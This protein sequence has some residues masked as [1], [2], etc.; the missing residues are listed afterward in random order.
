MKF[1]DLYIS[2]FDHVVASPET[3]REVLNMKDKNRIRF[4]ALV[5][6]VLLICALATTAFAYTGFV[7]YENPK[8]MIDAFFCGSGSDEG[9]IVVDENGQT[10]VYPSF[11]REGMN[12]SAAE[13]YVAPFTYEVGQSVTAGENKLT[14]DGY[15][16]DANTQC[17]LIYMCLEMPGGFPEYKVA[18]SGQ[19]I[20]QGQEQVRAS[21]DVTVFL[22][23]VEDTKMTLAGYFCVPDYYEDS[24]FSL[25]LNN[26]QNR[27]DPKLNM[28]LENVGDMQCISAGN[29]GIQLAPFAMVVHGDMLDILTESKETNPF[30]LAVSYADGSEYIICDETGEIPLMNYIHGYMERGDMNDGYVSDR[31]C[32][33]YI[34]DRVVNLEQITE[35]VVDGVPYQVD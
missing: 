6:A 9:A 33:T 34:L 28:P 8:Q 1:E 2:T 32:A 27:N 29:G 13:E 14:V 15:A 30:Y 16:Y 24:E 5:A 20:W 12:E 26:G 18:K 3:V 10:L 11:Q 35:I 22:N 25:Y 17:G 19:L 4:P 7:V 21:F 23:D 31:Y